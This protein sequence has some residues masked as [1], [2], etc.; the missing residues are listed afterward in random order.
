MMMMKILYLNKYMKKKELIDDLILLKKDENNINDIKECVRKNDNIKEA[1]KESNFNNYKLIFKLLEQY[2]IPNIIDIIYTF[3]IPQ[4]ICESVKKDDIFY[5]KYI[6][7][8]T[9]Y[10]KYIFQDVV[11]YKNYF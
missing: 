4:F 10:I 5:K 7:Y 9:K 1:Y 6:K 3:L 8:K 11:K 2:F